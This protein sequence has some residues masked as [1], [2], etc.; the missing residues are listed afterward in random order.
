MILTADITEKSFGTN[1]LYKDVHIT[2]QEKEKIGLVGRNG[3]GKSTLFKIL[4]GEDADFQGEVT[5]KRGTVLVSGRQEHHAFDDM[6]VLEY[7]QGDLPEYKALTEIID[8][9]PATMGD[10]PKK[11]QMFSDALERFTHLGYYQ[12]EDELSQALTQYQLPANILHRTL[13]SLSGGQKRL[14]ELIKIQRSRGHLASIDAPT[15]HMDHVAKAAFITWLTSTEEAVLVITH[16]RDVLDVVDRIVEIRDGASVN[17]RGN[18]AAYLRTNTSQMGSQVNEYD[19][20]QRRIENLRQDVLRFRRL[21]ERSR[22]PGTIRRFKSQ[23]QKAAEE[24]AALESV[25]KPSFWIDQASVTTINDKLA[26]TYDRYKAANIKV[27]TKSRDASNHGRVLVQC[28]DLSLGYGDKPLFADISMILREGERIRLHGR[29]GAGKTTL[30]HAIMAAAQHA[31]SASNCFAGTVSVAP[32]IGIG[33]YEQEINQAY[34]P[35]TLDAAIEHILRSSG[36][37]V[38]MQKI[39]QLQSDYLFNPASDGELPV[40]ILS[41]GQKARLQLIAMLAGD[42]KLLIL[43]EPTNHLDL[44]SIE[45]LEHALKKYEGAVMYISH[46]SY[47]AA[48]LGGE[49][50]QLGST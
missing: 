47:F 25:D 29:N 32:E 6:A 17:F 40:A 44:P 41:G 31:P 4:T 10:N 39:K 22:D 24:L 50:L 49:T 28:Q 9:Y 1:V 8:T 30:V 2:V 16:D 5:I 14:V 15:P 11:I 35:L 19:Q 12:L 7:V 48:A 20:T 38:S 36:Q 34:M 3:T 46:D 18:Y 27:R 45:E 42:P 23:E 21:K 33:V 37:A 13:G 26:K 43:D